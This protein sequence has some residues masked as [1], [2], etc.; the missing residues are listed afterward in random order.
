MVISGVCLLKH[1]IDAAS[2]CLPEVVIRSGMLF[3]ASVFSLSLVCFYIVVVE[4][5]SLSSESINVRFPCFFVSCGD[6]VVL[7]YVVFPI[8]LIVALQSIRVQVFVRSEH[9][10]M[11]DLLVFW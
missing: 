9:R 8:S 1:R 2:L 3:L 6:F 11:L 7:V 5:K 4:Y 10:L